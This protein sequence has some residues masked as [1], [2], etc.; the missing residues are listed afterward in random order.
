M[1]SGQFWRD[2]PNP[3]I[4]LVREPG[5]PACR[6]A[7]ERRQAY[8]SWFAAD[9]YSDPGS[10]QRIQASLGW[11][12]AHTRDVLEL[13]DAELILPGVWIW[14]LIE[15]RRRLTGPAG[16][17]SKRLI[18]S[19]CP[20]C[21]SE[22]AAVELAVT[23]LVEANDHPTVRRRL[24]TSSPLCLPHLRMAVRRYPKDA[25][26]A[27]VPVSQEAW[28]ERPASLLGIDPD[29][30]RRVRLHRSLPDADMWEDLA[31]GRC[32][33]CAAAVRGEG[34]VQ[35]TAYGALCRRHLCEGGTEALR[36]VDP[37]LLD[38]DYCAS[39]ALARR[40]EAIL[41]DELD[42]LARDEREPRVS[43]L[44]AGVCLRHVASMTAGGHPF[45]RRAAPVAAQTVTAMMLA[46]HEVID[47]WSIDDQRPATIAE[48]N[49]WR[50][51]PA[52]LDGRV[53]L[54]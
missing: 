26:R 42:R 48:Q 15:V 18:S 11:C 25:Y 3:A 20:I 30:P 19:A 50:E 7:N 17:R 33:V 39:C 36:G 5:C 29:A 8:L 53:L 46:L 13:T 22:E 38:D 41:T 35:P 10:L 9:N 16:V 49:A 32:P 44:A 34:A 12:D 14:V 54:G 28:A 6:T 2:L 24:A 1:A 37:G 40:D 23:T 47:K 27:L 4:D 21:A 51:V 43:L 45:R 31:A 52:R